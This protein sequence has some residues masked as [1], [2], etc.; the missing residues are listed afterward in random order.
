VISGCG[1]LIVVTSRFPFGTQ[2]AY[3]TAELGELVKHFGRVAVVPVRKPGGPARHPVP[4]G[5]EVVAWPLVNFALL[6]RAARAVFARPRASLKAIAAVIGSRDR[7]LAKNAS[8]ILKG[9][10]LADWARE[11]R[12]EHIHAYW[13]STPSTVAMIAGLS[14]GIPWSA[15]AHRWDIY[16]QNAFDAKERSVAFVRAISTRGAADIKKRMPFLGDR[17]LE[18]RLGTVV[19]ETVSE[20]PQYGTEFSVVCPAA[21]VPVK[22]HDVLLEA[23]VR[24]RRDGI[25]GRCKSWVS[26]APSSSP[27]SFPRRACTTGIVRGDSRPSCFPAVPT[28]KR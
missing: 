28:E 16:E 26:K 5:V 17:V 22:G 1:R 10:A 6:K 13:M 7:G 21:L 8:V 9:L 2:E 27:D 20:L 15:T 25:P 19:P 18:L 14:S 24:L 3:L 12:I 11:A 4:A 23:L